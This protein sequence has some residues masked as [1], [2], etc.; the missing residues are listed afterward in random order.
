MRPSRTP[1][2]ILLAL[3]LGSFP[4]A[5]C[6]AAGFNA[7][8]S[9]NGVDVWAVGT[10]GA[11][12]RSFDGGDTWTATTL[13]TGTLRGVAARNLTVVAVGDDGRIYRSLNSGGAW[14]LQ[15][16]PGAPHLRG[17][18]M[19]DDSTGWVVGNAGTILKT[20]DGGASWTPQAS[21]TSANLNAVRFTGLLTGYAAGDNGTVLRTVDGGDTWT[22]L[23]TGSSSRLNAVDVAGATVWV[24]GN[25][26]TA[27]RSVNGGD[28]WT[29]IDL[30]IISRANVTGVRVDSASV[31]LVGG[32]GFIRQSADGGATWSFPLHPLLAEVTDIFFTGPKAWVTNRNNTTVMRTADG[33]T[34]WLLPAGTT[35]S[36]A[37]VQKLSTGAT[38]RGSTLCIHPTNNNTYYACFGG[39]VR[40]SQN[41]G[42]TWASVATI[43][44]TFKTNAFYVSPG[45][46]MLM[47]AAVNANVGDRIVRSIDG[48]ANW[49]T[50]LTADFGEY[51]VPLEMDVRDPDHLLFAPEDGNLY[52]STDFGATWAVLSSPGFRSPCDIQIV[53]DSS[54]VVWV[55]D[56][57]TSGGF[58]DLFVSKDGGLTFDL[59]YQVAGTEIPMIA[60][61]RLQ[62][63]VG[64]ACAW[65][66]GGVRKTVNYGET[67][68][69]VA[70]TIRAWG[71]DIAADDPNVVMY[72]VYSGQMSYL[73]LDQGATFAADP[74][75]GANYSIFMP[76]RGTL[77]AE[78]SSGIFK[79]NVTYTTTPVT[80]QSVAVITP[81]GGESWAGGSQQ[82]LAWSS[83]NVAIVRVEYR[84]QPGDP[85]LWV[86]DVPASQD[87]LSWTVP[88]HPTSEARI[89]VSDANDG[90]PLDSSDVFTILVAELTVETAGIDFGSQ[91]VGSVTLDS[92]VVKN[93]GT[94]AI[95]IG[96]IATADTIFTA[97]R[98]TLTLLPGERDTIGVLFRPDAA[99]AYT[100]TLVF[101]SNAPESPH[102]VPLA[103]TGTQTSAAGD[104]APRP[105]VFVLRA[106]QP[107]PFRGTTRI[108]YALPARVRV[109]LDVFD[110]SGRL[111]ARL[112]RGEQGP[113][114][115]SADFGP[116]LVTAAGDRIGPI[117]S[118]IY[119]Y[120]L[121]AG[122]FSR[123]F[124]MILLR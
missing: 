77:L 89:R 117:P 33:G 10:A 8:Q 65:S 27:L 28:N 16:V 46:S 58:G 35:T 97:A 17:V 51:G 95:A 32:G 1:F 50:T 9:P 86:A 71:V 123:T 45:D 42:E 30:R 36:R 103:G 2:L 108:H 60:G 4:A 44:G 120:R 75:P 20:T 13:G 38:V 59:V 76:E 73:S 62:N 37:W 52:E 106:N 99:V 78:E 49:T 63:A 67:W 70:T 18:E 69:L 122:S 66:V 85:W 12:W 41:R 109:S 111:V 92:V 83:A 55:G 82:L 22:A 121:E 3:L 19:P 80:T 15:V 88:N 57:V 14:T 31:T 25:D 21:G 112:A 23:A 54:G 114:E 107:N 6:L 113:G 48:G 64:F 11:V 72:G 68:S 5:H 119:F 93:T 53:P 81:A 98:D 104:E 40:K 110:L 124:R 91:P 26:A 118:G 34:T 115:F 101:A 96:S 116:G 90:A 24:V 84:R 74:L 29:D 43:P 79:M 87:S 7:V 39:T 61:S 47:V 100:D 102:R 94:L 56:G 105:A